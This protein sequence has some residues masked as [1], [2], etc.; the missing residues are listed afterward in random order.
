MIPDLRSPINCDITTSS[1]FPLRELAESKQ[2]PFDAGG[3][4]RSTHRRQRFDQ[5]S[6]GAQQLRGEPGPI[7]MKFRI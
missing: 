1:D 5:E 4:I 6:V 7:R 2:F 3:K